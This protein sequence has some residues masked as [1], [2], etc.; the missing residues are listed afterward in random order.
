MQI[1]LRKI[2]CAKGAKPASMFALCIEP[3]QKRMG[4]AFR[5]VDKQWIFVNPK[6]VTV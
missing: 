4:P 5:L 6:A 1:N 2:E 3:G